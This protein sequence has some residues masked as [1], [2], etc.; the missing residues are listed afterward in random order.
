MTTKKYQHLS[1]DNRCTIQQFITFGRTFTEIANRLGKDRTTISKE[2]R[3]HRFPLDKGKMPTCL[4]LKRP[5][6]VCNGCESRKNCS[7]KRYL[8]DAKV[9][10]N[11]YR[12]TLSIERA[13]IKL[14]KDEI[15]TINA[16]VSPLM[17][18]QHHSINQVYIEHPECLPI[19]KS[20]FYRY[21]DLGFVDVKNIDLARKVRYK[22]KKAYVEESPAKEKLINEAKLGHMY[23]NF[24]DYIELH[25][26]A[27]IVEMDTVIGT[28]GGKG[29]KCFLTLL[30]RQYNFMLIY[31]L[32]Y[33]RQE[34][35]TRVFLKLRDLL[36]DEEYKRL[37]EVI[38]TDNGTEFNDAKSIMFSLETG[39]LLSNLFYCDS[40]S[41]WQKGSIERNHQ[42][43]RY[44]LP[45]GT[46]FAGLTQEDCTLLASHINSTP[47]RSLNNRTPFEAALGFLGEKNMSVFGITEIPKDEVN[48]SIR[49]LRK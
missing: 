2:I 19:S 14:S 1:Y 44:V 46:S 40:Y 4:K 36:G 26:Q 49:L 18:H 34:Y 39:E 23:G 5:P 15:D 41:A 33:K 8:Y 11:E 13:A 21:I 28:S 31:L 9:A 20:T 32:P 16:V 29:G 6:Y 30:F 7:F 35:V 38:L 24:I 22:P 12:K 27:S 3:I 47:R 43:I 37:F 48:L 42:Y 10:H 45:K 17:I 25:P